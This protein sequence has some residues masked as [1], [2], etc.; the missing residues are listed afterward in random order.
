VFCNCDDAVNENDDTKTSA[1]ALYFLRN[2]KE[3]GLKKLICTHYVSK[4]D[5]FR[6]GSKGYAYF[7]ILTKD[8]GKGEYKY[9][10]NFDGSF[11]HPISI[12]ILNDEAD[13]V[14]TNPPFSRARDYW[15]LIIESGKQFLIISN[16]TNIKNQPYMSYIK[17]NKVRPGYNRVLSYLNPYKQI[18]MASG[19]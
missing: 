17:D 4:E 9:P 1:F 13:I 7:Y 14:C 11:D 6:A 16:Q 12:Q 3:L 10:K 19:H 18:V 15:K 8:G 2:F 5:L